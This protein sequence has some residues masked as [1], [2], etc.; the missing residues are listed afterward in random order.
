MARLRMLSARNPVP[1]LINF[2]AAVAALLALIGII[3]TLAGWILAV[4]FALR[5]R[6]APTALR[7]VTILKPLHGDEPLL[8]AALTSVCT[9]DYPTYQVV[10]GVQSPTDSA[11]AIVRRLQS[12]FPGRDIALVINAARHGPNLKVGNLIN[13]LTAARHD[14]LVI[15]D[16]DLHVRPDYLH[17]LVATLEQ[18]ATG[19][20]TTLYAGLPASNGLPPRLGATQITHAFLPGALLARAMGRQDCLG[21]TMALRRSTLQRIGGFEA[22]VEHLADDNALGRLVRATGLAVRLAP[23]IPLTTVPEDTCAALFRHELRWARTIRA[24]APGPFA[25]SCLQYPIF[26]GLLALILAPA[27][28]WVPALLAWLVRFAAAR[29]I[30]RAIAPLTSSPPPHFKGWLL[31]LRELMSVAVMIASYAGLRVDWRGH[32]MIADGPASPKERA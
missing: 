20:A 5:R 14:I 30:D 9:L 22:L 3:Q 7:P 18:P 32:T 6:P 16:S 8:E 12:H 4:R 15:A 29:G 26:W 13:M 2:L 11:A 21:A 24:L 28:G 23:T 25:A 17:A 19:L 31:P 1:S 10:F 27:W